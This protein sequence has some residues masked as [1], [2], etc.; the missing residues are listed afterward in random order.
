LG[1]RRGE[2][3]AR[4]V[5]G[6][7]WKARLRSGLAPLAVS[8]AEDPE[9]VEIGKAELE[10]L[11][12]DLATAATAAANSKRDATAAARRHD[13]GQRL[14]T[15]LLEALGI[16]SLPDDE[17][18]RKQVI[19]EL[20]RGADERRKGKT[21][22]ADEVKAMLEARDKKHV[23]EIEDA[24]AA[25]DRRFK[26]LREEM[27]TAAAISAAA[28]H[29]ATAGG[30][31]V[32]GMMIDRE[33]DVLEEDGE[34]VAVV[35]GKDGPRLNAKG[36]RMTIAE[37]V[38]EIAADQEYAGL[39]AAAGS[40]GGGSAGGG[41]GADRGARP[42]MTEAEIDALPLDDRVKVQQDVLKGK[43]LLVR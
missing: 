6:Q 40:R 23:K 37:R 17:D 12:S 27:V 10:K 32:I 21:H 38:A 4:I 36:E 28:E 42:R 41:G 30:S 25:S 15:S 19:E 20:R 33:A 9:K 13:A 3:E 24:R 22:T 2:R 26:R 1:K 43:I 5:M 8:G 14:F 18:G 7:D 31:K 16:E 11:Q 34:L 29:R 39:F 35:K